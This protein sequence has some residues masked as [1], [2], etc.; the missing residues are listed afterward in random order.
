M[1][2]AVHAHP[3]SASYSHS[4]FAN[5]IGW[6][7]R[8]ALLIIDACLA[9]WTP[10]SP[11]DTTSNPAS[12]RAPDSMK[13]LLD[14]ARAGGVSVV[15]TRVVYDAHGGMQDAGIFW[16]KTKSLD[17]F[18]T[19]DERGL[20][21]WV[22]HAGLVPLEDETV[23]DKKYPSAFFGTDL[24]TRLHV[25]NVDTLVVCGVST[26]GCVRASVLDAMQY[27]YRPMVV[28][29]AC[30]DRSPQ[31]HNANMFDMNAK[32]ADIVSEEEAIQKLAAGWS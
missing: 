12:A 2:T 28:D 24:A 21:G 11:L 29:E 13:R 23:V 5:K 15:W 32:Y 10:G 3:D 8:P 6:G 19:G 17:I 4:G 16:R 20:G 27:G 26:S 25:L 18:Q 9:Y 31:I 7:A 14:A 30:G 1:S 22:A